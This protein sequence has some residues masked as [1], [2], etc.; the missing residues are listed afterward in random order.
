MSVLVLMVT[1]VAAGA[2]GFL[3][4]RLVAERLEL[5][6]RT[7]RRKL[8]L[9][10]VLRDPVL[11]FSV[12]MAAGLVFAALTSVWVAPVALVAA[13]ILSRRAPHMLDKRRRDDLRRACDRQL[14]TLADIVA[15]GMRGGLSFDAALALY[16]E[17]F[18]GELS[19]VM[20]AAQLKWRSGVAARE[21][22]LKDAA[23]QV[24]S[25]LVKRFSDTV[26]QA[27]GY[28]SPLAGMLT[29][30]ARDIRRERFAQIE[31]QV[32]KVPIKMLVPTG[33]CIL[34]AM[35]VLIMGPVLIQFIGSS[36]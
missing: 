1:L 36:F 32:E 16:C 2:A 22:A 3:L 11:C 13:I 34:P 23:D 31:R 15:M 28:G 29:T 5:H 20:R 9:E 6:V 35:L 30:L 26:V 19:H 27:M 14:D 10:D 8:E 12:F 4:P 24:G 33:T 18:P 25:Q 17:K 21:R 7:H